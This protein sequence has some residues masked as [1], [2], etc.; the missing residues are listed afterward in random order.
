MKIESASVR[1]MR[2]YD[3]S[4]FEVCLTSSEATTPEL[5]DELRKEAARLADKAVGQFIQAKKA[6]EL[7]TEIRQQWL[8]E[9]AEAQPENERTPRAK[10]IIKYHKDAAFA[11]QFDYDYQD[12][13]QSPD[14]DQEGQ[15]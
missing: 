12:D 5:V 9:S 7:R 4:H 6:C 11:A 3:Y 15:P 13:W 10:A 1:V 8:L 2:S 14:G